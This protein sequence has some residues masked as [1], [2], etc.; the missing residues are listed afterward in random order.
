VITWIGGIFVINLEFDALFW[1]FD[2]CGHFDV[3]GGLTEDAQ[4]T[5]I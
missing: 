3:G 1:S 4:Y 5:I 2:R